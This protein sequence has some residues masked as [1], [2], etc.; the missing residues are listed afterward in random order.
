MNVHVP[1]LSSYAHEVLTQGGQIVHEVSEGQIQMT[2]Q[3]NEGETVLNRVFAEA[4]YLMQAGLAVVQ[5]V[6]LASSENSYRRVI[7]SA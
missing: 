7:I 3:T 4:S 1:M 6:T 5:S 2:L